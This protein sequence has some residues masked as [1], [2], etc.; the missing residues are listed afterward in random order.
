MNFEIKRL[1]I[2][3]IFPIKVKVLFCKILINFSISK[4]FGSML[5][6]VI[7]SNFA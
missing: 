4:G 1:L 2:I 6:S 5:S 3:L 7:L